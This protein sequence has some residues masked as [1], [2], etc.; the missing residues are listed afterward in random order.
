MSYALECTS[1]IYDS[2]A[3]L[4]DLG[5][6][7]KPNGFSTFTFTVRES[8]CL[9]SLWNCFLFD[10]Q[11]CRAFSC[12]LP[13]T[14]SNHFVVIFK[15][16]LS[17]S[18]NGFSSTKPQ[19]GQTPILTKFLFLFCA[20]MYFNWFWQST[21]FSRITILAAFAE[22]WLIWLEKSKYGYSACCHTT[23]SD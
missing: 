17:S 5:I 12:Q 13:L 22:K 3:I 15:N 21:M 7:G 11:C 16:Q 14:L 19:E 2:G 18:L 10:V 8:M 1:T 9:I 23:T 20:F 4:L 6:H